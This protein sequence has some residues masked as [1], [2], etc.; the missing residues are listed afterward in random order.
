MSSSIFTV[1]SI[2][3]GLVATASFK[4]GN[5]TDY[6]EI[7]IAEYEKTIGKV[8]GTGTVVAFIPDKKVFINDTEGY[9]Y[10]R[11]CSEIK[12]ISYLNKGIK[13]IVETVT[14]K[15]EIYYSEKGIVDFIT[16]NTKKPLMKSPIITSKSNGEDEVEVAF[17]WTGDKSQDYVFV[18]GLFCPNGGTPIT[19]AKTA[20]TNQLKKYIGKDISPDS[21]RKGLAYVVNCKVLSPSFEGQT[22][23]KIN[24]PSLKTLTN[25][26][27]KEGL[28]YFVKTSEFSNIADLIKR[29]DKADK[30]ADKARELI[31]N[32]NKEIEK[33]TKKKI[34]LAEKL[35]DCKKH[36]ENSC[37]FLV[38]G[39]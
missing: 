1:K 17:M 15:K 33:E 34:I 3:D 6:S 2:R 12:N 13:F 38:E 5:L 26:A 16:D 30:A 14:G 8:K 9:S 20:I 25:E 10:E 18:N 32:S 39:K 28:E 11:I 31:L 29:Y 24:N 21:F 22:K 19:G 4:E 7:S 37:L 23:S 27:F 36:D 35:V